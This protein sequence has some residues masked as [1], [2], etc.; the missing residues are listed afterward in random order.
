MTNG[1]DV[2]TFPRHLLPKSKVRSKRI[3]AHRICRAS[4]H[5]GICPLVFFC[6]LSDFDLNHLS[7]FR[8][9]FDA[10]TC[11]CVASVG[12]FQRLSGSRG[13]AGGDGT[14]ARHGGKVARSSVM[15][16]GRR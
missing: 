13:G 9:S 8:P 6:L 3:I 1:G 11:A 14:A 16:T 12:R 10:G 15:T 4:D 7:F 5:Y 2:N